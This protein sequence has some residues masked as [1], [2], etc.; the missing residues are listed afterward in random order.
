MR[1]ECP[2]PS[3]T[4]ELVTLGHG[5]GGKLT[6]RLVTELFLPAFDNDALR[7]LHDGAVV[8]APRGDRLALTTDSFV[9]SPPFFRGGD[10]GSLAVHGTV[11]DLAMCGAR[12]LF[13]ALSLILEE[14]FPL[15]DL[16]RV[17]RSV[18]ESSRAARVQVVTGDTK[19]VERG[20]GDGIF[21]TT[22]GIGEIVPG[23]EISPRRVSAGDS[24]LVSGSIAEHGI[25]ILSLRDGL[26][27]DTEL[28]SDTASLWPLV[29]SVLACAGD[30]VHALRDATRGGVASVLNEIA[31]SARVGIRIEGERVPV[32]EEVRGAC[33][34]LGLDPLYVANEGKCVAFVAAG[35]GD[36][37]L[38]TMRRSALGRDARVIGEVVDDHPGV[39]RLSTGFGGSRVLDMLSGE[40]LPR[41][42]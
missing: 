15:S 37:V 12:P 9:V 42:C 30:R 32:R 18:S 21:I 14:G 4:R 11:N 19:V 29:E 2:V 31:R 17:L 6:H 38:R 7:E 23:I 35:C 34:V 41:I 28:A 33:E 24:V 26:S 27:F 1:F 25:S 10:I 3:R 36:E 13:L 16:S 8:P 20:K 40:Q 5:G 22:T 39:V